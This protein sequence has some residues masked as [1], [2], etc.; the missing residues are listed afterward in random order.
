VLR[1]NGSAG[2]GCGPRRANKEVVMPSRSW[3]KN[4]EAVSMAIW[5]KVRSSRK[6]WNQS[7]LTDI[8]KDAIDIQM[9]AL[10]VGEI[11]F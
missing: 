4:A 11:A 5:E 7:M 9:D 3:D 6:G 8:V 10:D 2:M 1:S